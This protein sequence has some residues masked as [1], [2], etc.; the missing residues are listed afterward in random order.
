VKRIKTAPEYDEW[1]EGL[2]DR[3][4]AVN[5]GVRIRRLAEGNP[6]DSRFLGKVSELKIPYGPGY[7]VYYMDT[8]REI[9]ILL[10]G[11]DKS[12]QQEDIKKARRI[13]A[14]YVEEAKHDGG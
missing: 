13:A 9:I 1:K 7:R 12:S 10:C 4:A 8:G 11:G 14:R 6:G 2:R 5:I 3:R